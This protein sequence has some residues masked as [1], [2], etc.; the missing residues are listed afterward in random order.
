M[1]GD[2][3][4]GD[5]VIEGWLVKAPEKVGKA[6]R[7]YFV[8]R[9]NE[10]SYYAAHKNGQPADKKG[11]FLIYP[12][13]EIILNV[14][15]L[16]IEDED[17]LWKLEG[18]D[19]LGVSKWYKALTA[20]R[21][22]LI[23]DQPNTELDVEV[24]PGKGIW[25][26][27]NNAREGSRKYFTLLMGSRSKQ[28]KWTYFADVVNGKGVGKQGFVEVAKATVMLLTENVIQLVSRVWF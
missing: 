16:M 9:G 4:L 6:R 26:G 13:S 3:S 17:R 7:R 8:V 20:I 23:V 21:D 18:D 24:L 19:S 1:D 28:L 12:N 14:K 10:V 5:V 2:E 15:T 25:L 22:R 11:S 27:L